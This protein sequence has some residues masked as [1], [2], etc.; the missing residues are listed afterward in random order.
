M[1]S[2]RR[3]LAAA[4]SADTGKVG[5]KDVHEIASTGKEGS[6]QEKA[7][8]KSFLSRQPLWLIL[9]VAS[10][11]CAALNGVFAKLYAQ[12]IDIAVL[13]NVELDMLIPKLVKIE[14]PLT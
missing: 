7:A 12:E 8:M 2:R 3:K 9:S 1:A 14:Q 10:G 4:G 5:S 6:Q 13:S 11:A